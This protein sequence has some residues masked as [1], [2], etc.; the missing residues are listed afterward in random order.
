MINA[1]FMFEAFLYFAKEGRLHFIIETA[2]RCRLCIVCWAFQKVNKFQLQIYIFHHLSILAISTNFLNC[3]HENPFYLRHSSSS[4]THLFAYL[5]S[6][7]ARNGQR[8]E[9]E[10]RKVKV[11]QHSGKLTLTNNF[12]TNRTLR[13]TF[14]QHIC[15][16][17]YYFHSRC[18]PCL[19]ALKMVLLVEQLKH[20]SWALVGR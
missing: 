10:M 7:A 19:L 17:I 4:D 18:A 3:C 14:V 6:A 16:K 9:R 2:V 8:C 15:I 20:E 12:K 5:Y 13:W 1:L 11:W